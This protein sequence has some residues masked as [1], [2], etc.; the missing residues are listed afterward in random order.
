MV[1]MNQSKSG[2]NKLISIICPAYNEEKNIPIFYDRINR[3]MESLC[4][5]YD[6]E[7]IFTNNRSTDGTLDAMMAVY[8]EDPN[9]QILTM[10]R[11]FGYQGSILGGMKHAK[12][13]AVIVI[14]ADCE[15]PPELLPQF[16]EKWEEGHDI[17]YGIRGQR[18]MWWVEKEARDLF[19]R[20]L[21]KTADMDIVLYMAEFALISGHVKDVAI[22]TNNTFPFIRAEIGYAGFSRYGIHYD[23]LP[24]PSGKSN[25][26]IFGMF[27]FAIAGVLTSSTFLF[28]F[29]FYALPF[30]A[31]INFAFLF[32][33]TIGTGGWA[34][35][36]LVTLD[37]I[38]LISLITL[39][40]LYL[41]RIYKNQ[42]GRPPFIID[43]R[44]SRNRPYPN[45][46]YVSPA[47]LNSI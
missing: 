33:A 39:N 31:L 30:I 32:I 17:V 11:N 7:I 29:A 35:Q 25:Y 47:S 18:P 40:G 4:D 45:E 19:Y 12:G 13:D 5:T 38:Y 34:F 27:A 21:K 6:F 1:D 26:N 9:V 24:R 8:R 37:L 22:N 16:L 44:L 46:T 2:G 42:I 10:S 28:R 41:A 36:L 15:D 3:V 20:V 43:P 14:D 23:R